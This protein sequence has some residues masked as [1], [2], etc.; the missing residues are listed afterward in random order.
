MRRAEFVHRSMLAWANIPTDDIVELPHV[1]DAVEKIADAIHAREPFDEDEPKTPA[2]PIGSPIQGYNWN[3][4]T[5]WD[6][7]VLLEEV[8]RVL[9][10]I[11]SQTNWGHVE[12]VTA[13]TD[14]RAKFGRAK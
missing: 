10:V 2:P 1:L 13:L 8:D 7:K 4:A 3:N 12:E 5:L 14:A 11:R 9:A 6:L